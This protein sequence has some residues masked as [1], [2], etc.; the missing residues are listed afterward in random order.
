MGDIERHVDRMIHYWLI[1]EANLKRLAEVVPS[2]EQAEI[3]KVQC[4]V[5]LAPADHNRRNRSWWNG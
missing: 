3:S 1:R 4:Q 5:R 2:A